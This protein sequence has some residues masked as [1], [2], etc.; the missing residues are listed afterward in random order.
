MKKIIVCLVAVAFVA[1]IVSVSF[2]R[3][4]A[5][6]KEA[7]REYL[8]VLDAKL[9]KAKN[10]G[11]SAKVN[12][13]HAEKNSTLARWNKL[14]ASMEPKPV[15]MIPEPVVIVVPG[16]TPDPVIVTVKSTKEVGRGVALYVNGGID[17]GLTGFSG[18][19]DY[20]LSGFPAQGL[21]LR[22]GANYVSGTNPTGNDDMKAVFAKVGGVYYITPYLPDFGIP[23]T[24]Y[25]GSAYLIPV[26]V[27]N[28]R[29]GVWG[30]EAFIGSNYNV[31]ELGVIN[32]EVGYAG[33]KYSNDQS[34]LK[35]MDLKIGYGIIF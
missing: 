14:K 19:L 16:P 23:L 5:E 4:M 3:T 1:G 13:L 22:V 34:A 32:V 31:P 30:V 25:V 27:N 20:D 12:L 6:E 8:F 35:G 33:L 24:W 18:N 15:A 29:T 7:V 2:G 28:N 26:K 17:S 11:Q 10:A 21:K 9:A